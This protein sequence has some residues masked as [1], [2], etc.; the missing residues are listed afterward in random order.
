MNIISQLS[1]EIVIKVL[2]PSNNDI[3]ENMKNM[4]G[5]DIS[6]SINKI[7]SEN[8]SRIKYKR[9]FVGKNKFFKK[10]N[11]SFSILEQNMKN[12]EK[13]NDKFYIDSFNNFNDDKNIMVFFFFFF[14][15][16][17]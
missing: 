10:Y 5:F 12:L 14:V 2:H 6:K 15:Y 1:K 9:L 16:K 17:N 3:K 7:N 13:F 4:I 8:R 11:K